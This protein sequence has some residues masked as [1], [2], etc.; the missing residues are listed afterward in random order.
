MKPFRERNPVPIG[1]IGI[2]ILAV[3]LALAFNVERLPLIG[4]GNL[5][6]ANFSEAGGLK[7][8]DQVRVAGVEV[9]QVESVELDGSHVRVAFRV[10]D[11]V[12][13]GK[14]SSIQ[15]KIA[16]VLG[17][18][19]LALAPKG[20]GAL[21]P[22]ASIPLSRTETP[23]NVIEAF[24]G[25]TERTQQIDTERLAK[26]FETLSTTFRDSPEEVRASLRGL[27]RLSQTI[28]SRN[29]KLNELLSYSE[30]VTKVLSERNREFVTLLQDA[31]KLLKE[32]DRR[33]EV[34][35]KLLVNTV[36]LSNQ[37]TALVEENQRELEPA[38]Q[39]LNDVVDIL[40]RNKEQLQRGMQ[41]LEPFVREFTDTLGTGPWF[42]TYIQNM[43]PVPTSVR[44]PG[45]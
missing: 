28:S 44:P 31:D 42:D 29:E 5:Y 14:R 22:G 34:I 38:L 18:R 35:H 25:L 2:A 13:F 39:R 17:E 24:S 26:S 36:E 30:N 37:L 33:R 3:L 32:L 9:G 6:Y 21:S 16:T 45:N 4:G 11:G 27:T 12:E 7:A 10:N 43:A 19:Y 20:Q 40:R 23:F 15:I 41:L 8:R 1:A